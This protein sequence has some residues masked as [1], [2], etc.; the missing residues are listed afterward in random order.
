M[1]HASVDRSAGPRRRPRSGD[2]RR[3][4]CIADLNG[5]GR[6]EVVEQTDYYEGG[7]TTAYELSTTGTLVP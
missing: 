7:S 3:Q 1:L 4:V 2:G 5:D 6:M